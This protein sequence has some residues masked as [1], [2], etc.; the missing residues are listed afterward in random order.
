MECK[1]RKTVSAGMCIVGLFSML[2]ADSLAA[3]PG[4]CLSDDEAALL[5]LI[6]QYRVN[7]GLS[8]VPWSKSLT[9][10]AQWHV[11]DAVQNG[12]SIFQPPCNPHSW[13]DMRPDLWSHMC[14]TPDHTQSEKMWIKPSEITDGVYGWYGYEI[15]ARNY[16]TV[17]AALNG[18]KGSQGHNDMILNQGIWQPQYLKWKAMGVGVGGTDPNY[19]IVWFSTVIDPQ[20]EVVPCSDLAIFDSG[21][22]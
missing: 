2:A 15:V 11:I 10:V 16:P 1:L 9:Q 20:G 5:T 7:N 22:E 21:F 6:D 19:Y 17:S 13:S 18:W 4:S 12:Q 8:K 3:A 14:Y